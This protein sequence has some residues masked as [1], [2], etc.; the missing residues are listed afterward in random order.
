ML[1]LPVR[2]E[3]RLVNMEW[4]DGLLRLSFECAGGERKTVWARKMVLAT[5]ID[6]GGRWYVPPFISDVLPSSCYAHTSQQID[7]QA[8]LLLCDAACVT[9]PPQDD[10]AL[11]RPEGRRE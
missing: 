7:Q 9:P 3:H 11:A 5:G 10:T 8:A 6:G 4:Q 1:E 2:N